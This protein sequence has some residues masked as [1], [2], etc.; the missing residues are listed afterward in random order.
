MA[1]PP[2][3][4]AQAAAAAGLR[5]AADTE[6][7]LRRVRRGRGFSYTDPQGRTVGP[8]ERERIAALAIPP[9]WT[10]VWINPDP[11]GHLLATGRDDR[12]R[13]VYRYHDRWR[14]VRDSAK[15][16]RL[17]TFADALPDLRAA[18]DGDLGRR[19]LPAEKVVA[20]VVRLLDDTLVRVG[21]ERYAEHNESFGL[22]TLRAQHADIH[23]DTVELDFVGKAGVAQRVALHDGRLARIARR[24]HELPGKHLFAYLDEEG[25]TRAVTSA[26]VNDYLRDHMGPEVSAKDF[27]TWG[28]TTVAASR[29]ARPCTDE[30]PCDALVRTSYEEAAAQLGNT[31]AICRTCYVHPA[32]PEAYREGALAEAWKGAR[33]T[34]AL[35]RGEQAVRRLLST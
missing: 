12:G 17:A 8:G 1:R 31:P 2:D 24:C 33:A 9:A 14:A 4:P 35:A 16:D 18:V 28:G 11:D 27:R 15:F 19:G 3:D 5:Y 25:D 32:V 30:Q 21:N 29:L 34:S 20:L 13:K 26:E 7:G 22:T 6:P 10:D 23:G